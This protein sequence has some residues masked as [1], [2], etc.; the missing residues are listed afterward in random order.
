M[1]AGVLAL[2]LFLLLSSLRSDF[3]IMALPVT[4]LLSPRTAAGSSL[5]RGLGA[6]EEEAE[7]ELAPAPFKFPAGARTEAAEARVPR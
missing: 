5:F 7:D 4:L 2:L 1:V 3:R 6:L